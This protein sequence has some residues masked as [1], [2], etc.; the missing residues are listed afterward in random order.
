MT[1]V[2]YNRETKDFDLIG[3]DGQY[4]GSRAT[5]TEARNAAL[6]HDLARFRR[7]QAVEDA[8]TSPVDIED[9]HTA[10]VER[11]LLDAVKLLAPL[12]TGQVGQVALAYCAHLSD[13]YGFQ[14]YTFEHVNENFS[15]AVRTY[16]MGQMTA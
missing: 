1:T 9:L 4:L 5:Y 15:N 2:Q 13:V 11:R 3:D 8:P 7:R 10:L 12:T 16:E 6:D 14:K